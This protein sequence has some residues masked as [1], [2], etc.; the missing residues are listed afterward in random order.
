MDIVCEGR[1]SVI[2][3]TYGEDAV[4]DER[5]ALMYSGDDKEM[6]KKFMEDFLRQK[7]V[8][9]G[10]LKGAFD[11]GNWHD[12]GIFAHGLKSS[13]LSLGGKKIAAAAKKL[14]QAGKDFDGG[15]DEE[16]KNAAVKYIKGHHEELFALYD[17]FAAKCRKFTEEG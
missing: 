4:F 11:E 17:E 16:E 15:A 1:L 3:K 6:L 5:S 8:V 10:R 2:R 13:A 14:E 9:E 12:Y 7:P